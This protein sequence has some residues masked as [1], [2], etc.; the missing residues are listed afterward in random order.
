M[1]EVHQVDRWLESLLMLKP[2]DR[3][4][5]DGP[6]YPGS[7]KTLLDFVDRKHLLRRIDANFDFAA[8]VEF[9]QTL[10]DPWIGRPAIHPEVVIRALVLMV[11]YQVPSERQVCERITENLAWRWFCHL[12]LEDAV[13]D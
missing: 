4:R 12:A 2:I 6:L 11:V 3:R 5:R 7:P 8:L 1:V 10:Y 13:F 9:L